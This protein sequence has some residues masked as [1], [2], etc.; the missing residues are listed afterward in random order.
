M[1]IGEG[2]WSVERELC[3]GEEAGAG[4]GQKRKR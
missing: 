3:D 1:G 4:L 2:A